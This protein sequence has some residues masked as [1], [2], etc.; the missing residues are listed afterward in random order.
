M[1]SAKKIKQ[2]EIDSLD[3]YFDYIVESKTNGQHKQAQTLYKDLSKKQK[4]MFK[5]W[6]ETCYYYECNDNEENPI[7]LIEKISLGTN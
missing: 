1:V 3:E 4:S 5:D 2:L 6:F 7:E